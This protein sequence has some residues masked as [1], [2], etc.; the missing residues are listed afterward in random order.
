MPNFPPNA[1]LLKPAQ[2][3]RVFRT[4]K[5]K[6]SSGPLRIFVIPNTLC[7]PRMGLAVPKRNINL[8]V[9]RNRAKRV[10]R[11]QFRLA[12]TSLPGIDIV[13]LVGQ[14]RDADVFSNKFSE[15]AQRVFVKLKQRMQ[16]MQETNT[17]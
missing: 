17:Q 1:R 16:D 10:I 12:Q 3:T 2:F 15:H 7:A 8:A 11:E 5:I 9:Q 4:A 14:P 13:V 6:I